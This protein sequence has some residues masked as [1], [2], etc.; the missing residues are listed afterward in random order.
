MIWTLGAP[1]DSG[2]QLAAG[3]IGRSTSP[4]ANNVTCNTAWPR[5]RKYLMLKWAYAYPPSRRAWKTSIAVVQ[6]DGLPPNQGSMYFA[7]IGWT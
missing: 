4:V 5:G 1:M 3:V 6:T 2:R 7:M